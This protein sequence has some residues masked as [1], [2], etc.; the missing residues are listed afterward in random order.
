MSWDD[1]HGRSRAVTAVL[2][3]ASRTGQTTLPFDLPPVT[4]AFGTPRELVQALQYKWSL[5]V[6]A[7]MDYA[8]FEDNQ[9]PGQAA[10]H[11]A[12]TATS[13]EP[14]LRELLDANEGMTSPDSL[15]T[16]YLAMVGHLAV[17]GGS[18]HPA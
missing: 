8:I 13:D 14:M 7:R 16:R 15:E 10:R 9:D 5:L 2:E 18:A 12:E 4:A 1:F 17:Q 11:A 3:H 6:T